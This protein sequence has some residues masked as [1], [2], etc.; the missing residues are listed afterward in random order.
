MALS[1]RQ[2]FIAIIFFA[3]FTA[4]A[5]TDTT[6]KSA[7]KLSEFSIEDLMN[8]KVVTSTGIEQTV[9]EAPS[10]MLV[11]TAQQIHDRGYEQLEDVLRDIPGV[12]IVHLNGY[13]PSYLYFRGLYG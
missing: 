9:N 2:L 6:N 5:Q 13:A 3:A 7:S 1:P 12:D 10:T 11:I 4:R 8:L